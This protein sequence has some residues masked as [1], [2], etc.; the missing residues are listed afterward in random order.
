MAP[1]ASQGQQG[2]E[3][4]PLF[5]TVFQNY[6]LKLKCTAVFQNYLLK[7]KCTVTGWGVRGSA[8]GLDGMPR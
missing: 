1:S 5:S 4:F 6:L 8:A 7:L 3:F 2:I